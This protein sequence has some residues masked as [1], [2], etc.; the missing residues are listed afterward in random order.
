[1][2][3]D[4]KWIFPQKRV[5]IEYVRQVARQISIILSRIYPKMWRTSSCFDKKCFCWVYII[6]YQPICHRTKKWISKFQD[7][8]SSFI[9]FCLDLSNY[10]LNVD[11]I[12]Y[13]SLSW[14]LVSKLFLLERAL[15]SQFNTSRQSKSVRI[16]SCRSE[17]FS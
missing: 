4:Y 15:C 14:L 6:L 8:W 7:N 1:M 2:L 11:C 5:E 12:W 10:L 16:S 3:S 17:S 9:T 13:D